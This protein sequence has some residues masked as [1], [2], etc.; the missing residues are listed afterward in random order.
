MRALRAGAP[1][2]PGASPRVVLAGRLGFA[3]ATTKW[4]VIELFVLYGVFY[5]IDEA[6]SK[7]FI[8]D[9]EPE[10]RASFVGSKARF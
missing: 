2:S 9:I 3:L 7:A 1:A 10:R 5:A 4:Q 6:Q 8:S